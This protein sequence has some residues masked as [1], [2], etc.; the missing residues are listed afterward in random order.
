M[1]EIKQF[2]K[3]G[4]ERYKIWLASMKAVPKSRFNRTLNDEDHTETFLDATGATVD[5][6]ERRNFDTALEFTVHLY[7]RL[8]GNNAQKK[9]SVVMI[10]ENP[11]V[12][13]WLVYHYFDVLC[14]KYTQ[15][16]QAGKYN[17]GE[18]ARYILDLEGRQKI[19]RHLV[20]GRLAVFATYPNVARP[21]ESLSRLCLTHSP[22][23]FSRAMDVI[24]STEDVFFNE[25]MMKVLNRLYWNNRTDKPKKKFTENKHPLQDGCLYRFVG[26]NSFYD[27]HHLTHDFRSM[28]EDE[29]IELM[30]SSCGT[31]FDGWLDQDQADEA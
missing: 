13:D 31:E 15:G 16:E 4:H 1:P 24:S 25:E 14:K 18:L 22:N 9:Q 2:S 10:M 3:E 17:V 12:A 23:T 26:P 8:N 28:T 29:I 27:Q 6:G 7:S 11:Q 19:Y 5:L 21:E 20:V 30:K